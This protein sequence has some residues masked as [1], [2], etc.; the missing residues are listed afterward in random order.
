MGLIKISSAD[1]L[2]GK[3]FAPGKW[4]P[5]KVTN[6]E[7]TMSKGQNPSTNYNWKLVAQPSGDPELDAFVGASPG[8]TFNEQGLD[9]RYAEFLDACGCTPDADGGYSV[10]PRSLIGKE[11]EVFVAHR[12]D[13]NDKTRIYNDCK[14]FRKKGA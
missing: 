5:V 6:F 1:V 4:Y 13:K 11:L 2:R 14:N 7:E 9:A 8:V 3:L 12:P 10:E